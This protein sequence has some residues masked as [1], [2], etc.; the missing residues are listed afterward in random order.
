[1]SDFREILKDT[2]AVVFNLFFFFFFFA[3][4]CK[5]SRCAV[6][7]SSFVYAIF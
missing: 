3:A 5:F 2:F 6:F 1:M 7:L 4:Q